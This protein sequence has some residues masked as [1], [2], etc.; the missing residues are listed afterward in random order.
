[1]EI[2]ES[3]TPGNEKWNEF[4]VL[5]DQSDVYIFTMVILSIYLRIQA[6]ENII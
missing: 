3:M 4:V 6:S 5:E 1:M 2:T